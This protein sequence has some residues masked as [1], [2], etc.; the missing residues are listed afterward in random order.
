MLRWQ[1]CDEVQGY[2]FSTP[3]PADDFGEM[4]LQQQF[5]RED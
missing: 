2:H 3:L 1:G 4:L 5:V